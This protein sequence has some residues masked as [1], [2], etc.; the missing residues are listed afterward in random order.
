AT[1]NNRFGLLGRSR[2][3]ISGNMKLI[4]ETAYA[5]VKVEVNA[6]FRGTVLPQEHRSLHPITADTFSIEL[7]LPTLAVDEL[8]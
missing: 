1:K 8:Y 7:E 2:A 3:K 4:I 6:V 5:Q